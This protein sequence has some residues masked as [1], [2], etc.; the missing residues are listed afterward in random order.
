[1]SRILGGLALAACLTLSSGYAVANLNMEV[2]PGFG[3]YH[4]YGHWLPI[5]IVLSGG[6]RRIVGEITLSARDETGARQTYACPADVFGSIRETREFYALPE[7]FRR[8]VHIS[9]I[10][11]SGEVIMGKDEP[12]SVISPGNTLV[13]VIER[14]RGGLD[15]LRSLPEKDDSQH[16]IY[17]SYSASYG[18]NWT[19]FPPGR[20]KGYDSVDV[21]VLGDISPM[22]LSP[23]QRQAIVDW[24]YAGGE[25]VVS[26]GAQSQRLL[27]TFV[28]DILPV[29]ITGTLVANSLPALAQR[30]GGRIGDEN[31]VLASCRLVDGGRSVVTGK[32]GLP[33]ITERRVG[34]GKVVFLAFGYLAPSLRIWEGKVRMWN[35]ILPQLQ[36]RYQVDSKA[37]SRALYSKLSVELPPYKVTGALMLLYFIFF[38]IASYAALKRLDNQVWKLLVILSVF[39][40]FSVVSFLLVHM[41]ESG[42]ATISDYSIVDVY[43]H[44]KRA[45]IESYF[46][47]LSP[48]LS[49]YEIRFGGSEAV[50]IKRLTNHSRAQSFGDLKLVESKNYRLEV[51]NPKALIPQLFRAESFVDLDGSVAADLSGGNGDGAVGKCTSNL[52]FDMT[53]CYFF[54]DGT[55]TYIGDLKNGVSTS[56]SRSGN[57]P[58]LYSAEN[59]ERQAFVNA[60]RQSLSRRLKGNVVV[61]W[62]QKSA[63]EEL[64]GMNM[65]IEHKTSGWALIIVHL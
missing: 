19:L 60:I 38:S 26:G 45:R 22:E 55:Y 37:I 23:A 44:A 47:L 9:L 62:V 50:F 21:L 52:G 3:G 10:D 53:D 11:K 49:E 34:D 32:D 27:G 41:S 31:I 24:I 58:G 39:A 30:F 43:Q 57:V 20:W 5:R 56:W 2:L 28:E 25:L 36:T 40:L 33:L 29:R 63:L 54:R 15:F 8:N 51:K 6:D 35:K 65:T 12:L 14:N 61:G 64:A 17:V 59:G 7:S 1:M 13:A 16:K 4:K 18:N 46:S 48:S 42:A